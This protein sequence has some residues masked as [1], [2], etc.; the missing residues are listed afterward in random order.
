MKGRKNMINLGLLLDNLVVMALCGLPLIAR[1]MGRCN[2]CRTLGRCI[3]KIS[4]FI[5]GLL[6]IILLLVS[7]VYT[8]VLLAMN[9]NCSLLNQVV[10]DFDAFQ[11]NVKDYLDEELGGYMK[12]CLATAGGDGDFMKKLNLED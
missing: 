7:T 2:A 1:L 9:D 8:P 10:N 5:S 11:V 6:A 12:T 3:I 4:W